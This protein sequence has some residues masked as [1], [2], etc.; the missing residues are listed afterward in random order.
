MK[1]HFDDDLI[2]ADDL[3]EEPDEGFDEEPEEDAKGGQDAPTDEKRKL[4]REIRKLKVQRNRQRLLIA[5][6]WIATVLFAGLFVWEHFRDRSLGQPAAVDAVMDKEISFDVPEELMTHFQK[7]YV[8]Y[9]EKAYVLFGTYPDC[10]Y[11]KVIAG[12]PRDDYDFEND[13]Y[14]LEGERYMSYNPDGVKKSR[15]AIDVS[16]Y[17][18]DVDWEAVKA[19]GVDV[20]IARSGFRGY[21]ED[22][23]LVE[24]S[25]FKNHIEGAL[26]AGLDCGVYFFTEAV[27]YEE[28]V[29]EAKYVLDQIRPYQLTQPIIVDTEKINAE[30]VRANDISNEDRTEALRG[31]CE[32]IKEAGYT[33][34]IY[35]STAWFCQAMDLSKLGEYE[36]WLAAYD[37]PQFPYHVEGWQYSS[38]GSVPGIEGDVDLNVWLR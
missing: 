17:Q 26:Q 8:N 2:E 32:T 16:T 11:Y 13:F 24:D 4:Q 20:V 6:L 23:T 15:V 3:I 29:E 30:G 34:M 35:A 10:S 19:S 27:N 38:T 31:F 12:I 28:G 21:G 36:W 25:Q 18:T 37:T 14:T 5:L 9:L 1:D 7:N 33:P 22:G